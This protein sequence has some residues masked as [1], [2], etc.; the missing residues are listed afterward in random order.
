LETTV[1]TLTPSAMTSSKSPWD[2][3]VRR[4]AE[5]RVEALPPIRLF[6]GASEPARMLRALVDPA[7][8]RPT[9]EI[10]TIRRLR[11]AVL[12]GSEGETIDFAFDA[13]T[14]RRGELTGE[15]DEL[16][17]TIR[18]EAPSIREGLVEAVESAYGIGWCS[19]IPSPA[20]AGCSTT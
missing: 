16:E 1:W 6:A 20:R 17:I 13:V 14:V 12:P 8:L 10:E 11:R 7:H 19:V 18:G 4:H 15:L 2:R 3:I 9:I 5:A